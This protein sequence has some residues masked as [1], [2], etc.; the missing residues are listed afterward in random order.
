MNNQSKSSAIQSHLEI[1]DIK[2]DVI[3]LKNGGMRAVLMT[4]SLNFAL[5]SSEEQD[6]V[7]YRYQE[8][9]NS[10]DFSIQIVAIS[11]KFNIDPYIQSLKAT[12]SQQENELLKIQTAE[13]IDFI[14]GLTEINDIMTESFYLAI[15]YSPPVSEKI[16]FL[17][18]ILKFNKNQQ[19]KEKNFPEMKNSLWQR[20]EFIVTGLSGMGIRAVPLNTNELIELF[21]KL[22]NPS[23]KEGPKIKPDSQLITK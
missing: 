16:G 10:L 7:I 21:Y 23:A 2:D 12:E 22:Y 3:I 17:S 13:Y 15:P 18:N 5:K 1:K 19:E 14:K 9:L 6:A 20:A 11:R 8:F 4:T